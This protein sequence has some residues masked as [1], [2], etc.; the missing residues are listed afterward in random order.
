MKRKTLDIM[1]SVGGLVL[2]GLL[3]IAGLVLSSNASFAKTYVHDQ[4]VDQAITFKAADALTADEKTVPC[5]TTYAGQQLLTGKQAECQAKLIGLHMSNMGKGVYGDKYLGLSYAELGSAQAPLRTAVTD[6]N[7]VL[8]A[9]NEKVTVAKANA[10]PNLANLQKDAATAQTAADAKAKELA[11][12][13]AQRE[14]VFKGESLRG[15]LLTA[16][17]FS[18]LGGKAGQA[19]IIA[20]LAAA[21][22]LLLSVFGFIHAMVTPGTK[23]FAAPERSESKPMVRA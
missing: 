8:A 19:A 14:S 1:F 2:A 21:L 20:Y 12:V 6:A 16:Y 11:D 15:V 23:A 5:L 22:M 13:T 10:D 3:L 17:G 4:M 18:E 7:K 9:A